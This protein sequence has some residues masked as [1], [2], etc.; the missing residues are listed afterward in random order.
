MD[1]QKITNNLLDRMP[2]RF[3]LDATFE[4]TVR[5]NLHC[6]MCLFR[7]SDHES[8]RLIREELTTKQWI[9]IAQEAA[10]MGTM[11]I[12]I[13]GG[14]PMLRP[15]F[16]EIYEAIYKMGFLITLYTNA[17]LVTPKI[18]ELL[19]R[20][21]PH[22]IGVTLY[23]ASPETYEKV[24]G[25][26]QAYEQ[27]LQGM[28][29]LHTLPSI[30][31]FRTT[32]IKDNYSDM[33]RMEELI[34]REFGQEYMLTHTRLVMKSVRGGCA[35]AGSCRLDPEQNVQLAFR[36]GISKIKEI[37]GES[38][39][40][41]N[42]AIELKD[43]KEDQKQNQQTISLFGCNAGMQS[44]TITWDGKLIG[45]Q[46]FDAFQTNAVED[47]LK[48]AWED[49]PFQVKLP[50]ISQKC[51]D[52]RSSR[53]CNCCY[54]LRY[55]ETGTLDGVPEYACADTAVVQEM[56]DRKEHSYGKE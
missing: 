7:H 42:L 55:A 16:C 22:R 2:D 39:D 6:K 31:E 53:F 11:S 14:E 23:G 50:K 29:K 26:A 48:Q 51:L 30:M 56:Y 54:A 37:Y 15:D 21:P 38:Y 40:E 18:M 45:C 27:A 10:Q 8:Q 52:C 1:G 44:Y 43:F 12:L 5:C 36:R 19:K 20:C 24:C 13:T 3:P 34:E 33:D 17:T 9:N 49:F 4:F 47:G 46:L 32:I 41:K 28:H 25:S 35:D